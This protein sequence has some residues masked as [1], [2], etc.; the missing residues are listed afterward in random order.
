GIT[1]CATSL[2]SVRVVMAPIFSFSSVHCKLFF[3][4]FLF[5][6]P[7]AKNILEPSFRVRAKRGKRCCKNER[8]CSPGSEV[9]RGLTSFTFR[10]G[11][12]R[13]SP[14]RRTRRKNG[15]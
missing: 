11:C 15:G 13:N 1:I 12:S 4:G 8:A 5:D 2:L 6:K 10:P 7:P 9:P 3:Y 14:Y